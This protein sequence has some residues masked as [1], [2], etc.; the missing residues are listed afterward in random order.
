M[1]I[2]KDVAQ[3][4]QAWML[5]LDTASRMYR[6][7][8]QDQLLI[9]AQKPEA[10]ACA[11]FA[12]WNSR[13]NRVVKAGTRGI[14]LID[15]HSERPRLNYVFDVGDTVK[16]IG[17]KN[18]Y[19]WRIPAGNEADLVKRL[20][21]RFDQHPENLLLDEF[22]HYLSIDSMAE[23]TANLVEELAERKAGSFLEE[24]DTDNLKA[25]FE[26]L[27]S[28]SLEYVL[29]QRCGIFPGDYFEPEDFQFITEFN[30]SDSL[31]L[32]GETIAQSARETLT[33]IGQ[34][35]KQ[36]QQELRQEQAKQRENPE[37]R[38]DNQGAD[39]YYTLKHESAQQAPFEQGGQDHGSEA[40]VPRGT[41][42]A[43][44]P[45]PD[46][47]GRGE[48]AGQV[49]KA[50]PEVPAGEQF[51][52]GSD[53]VREGPVVEPPVGGGR[54]GPEDGGRTGG[55][56]EA[57]RLRSVQD[58]ASLAYTG[59]DIRR[60]NRQSREQYFALEGLCLCRCAFIP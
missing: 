46:D 2:T 18:P 28:A 45:E 4:P 3:S 48:N 58:Q 36:M 31:T 16:R 7:S 51:P 26:S 53:A 56:D 38:L 59:L 19:L 17:G 11:T 57:K 29:F 1:S 30:T 49:R 54:T 13:F 24:L 27:A 35:S 6:Y 8:F 12:L 10:T 42:R 25:R 20:A 60:R 33:I 23:E 40:G 21:E 47:S 37:K 22:L 14:A 34:I 5:Y 39:D 55:A 43:D 50:P 15:Q 9:H 41:G 52:A 44:V 32:L